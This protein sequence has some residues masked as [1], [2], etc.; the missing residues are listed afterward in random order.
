MKKGEREWEKEVTAVG[1]RHR[2]RRAS[3]E[4]FCNGHHSLLNVVVVFCHA[5]VRTAGESEKQP[6]R[7]STSLILKGWLKWMQLPKRHWKDRVHEICCCGLLSFWAI[8]KDSRFCHRRAERS[9]LS[10][11]RRALLKRE[12]SVQWN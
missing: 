8:Q 9:R 12:K 3:R 7:D 11:N 2:R 1:Q 4:R 6:L 10:Y 5:G